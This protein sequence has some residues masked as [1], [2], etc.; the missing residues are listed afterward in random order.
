MTEKSTPPNCVIKATKAYEAANDKIKQFMTENLKQEKKSS[1]SLKEIN[2][3]FR[4]WFIS[5]LGSNAKIPKKEELE[6]YLITKFKKEFKL[7]NKK[8]MGYAF[9]IDL[10]DEYDENDANAESSESEQDNPYIYDS[11]PQFGVQDDY[12]SDGNARGELRDPIASDSDQDTTFREMLERKMRKEKSKSQKESDSARESARDSVRESVP[13]ET[14]KKQVGRNQHSLVRNRTI[15]TSSSDSDEMFAQEP[16]YK[17]KNYVSDIEVPSDSN[18][19]ISIPSSSKS[20]RKTFMTDDSDSTKQSSII[21]LQKK[22][23]AKMKIEQDSTESEKLIFEKFSDEGSSESE[24]NVFDLNKVRERALKNI[25]KTKKKNLEKGESSD[26]S[27]KTNK[28]LTSVERK[29]AALQN[30]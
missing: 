4:K 30:L 27:N 20:Q 28:M 6:K 21:P 2:S 24:N 7:Q 25:A 12:L 29:K 15:K 8:L 1:L 10:P 5:E 26:S 13:S 3:N 17:K 11:D 19:S 16:T 18:N 9:A 23:I 14:S 22:K